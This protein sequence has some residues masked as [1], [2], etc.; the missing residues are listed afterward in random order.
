MFARL[1]ALIAL[2]LSLNAWAAVD[3]NKA[4]VADLDG[5]K[6][7]GPAMSARIVA[8]R[9]KSPFKDWHDFT[10]RVSGVG[11]KTAEK[12]SAEGL[13]INGR[14]FS[15]AAYAKAQARQEKAKDKAD[16]TGAERK[17]ASSPAG[18]APASAPTQTAQGTSAATAPAV[19]ASR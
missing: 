14:K 13:T 16:K 2:C 10:Q 18:S 11:E 12:L 17:P 1:I 4:S 15:A 7:I 9:E 6:G 3:A 5:V 19:A 8:E